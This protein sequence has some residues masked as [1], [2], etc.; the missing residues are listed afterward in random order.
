MAYYS[1]TAYSSRRPAGG[2]RSGGYQGRSGGGSKGRTKQY[3]NPTRFIC[4]AK[5]AEADVYVSE[6]SFDDFLIHP[7]LKQNMMT[8]G[9]VSPSQIQDKAIPHGLLGKDIVGIANTGTGK[10][11]A[12]AVP[13][14]HKL[15]EDRTARALIM[16]PTRELASQIEQECRNLAKASGLTGVVLVGGVPIYPQKRDLRHHPSIVIGTPGRI[17]DHIEQKTLEISKFN[18]VVLDEVDRMLD[19]GFINDIRSILDKLP[20]DRQSLFFSAT[21]D[22]KIES[23]VHSFLS[24]PVVISVK[25]AETSDNVEQGIIRASGKSEKIK[26]LHEVL[27][28]DNVAKVLI[29]DE[30]Q[31]SVESLS[32]ELL[33][34]GFS[35]DALHGGKS[36]P[37]RTRAL[38][39]FKN[40]EVTVLVAT[41]VAARGID[42]SDITH[43]INFTTPM[44]YEDYVHRIG[45]AGRAGR[46]GYAL[47]FVGE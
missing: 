35:A 2:R 30:T 10:T 21:M 33:S 22:P 15:M 32:Q 47:T 14:L 45:R 17:K 16:A 1:S 41:D 3:I 5:M 20:R 6:N 23:L 12:F 25:T 37:Q 13:M 24:D 7:T 40:S 38:K 39:R 19:M 29:F 46:M 11:A 42:I 28:Q 44:S 9:F 36:Q 31:R 26:K 27:L 43:V 34:R 4:S 18:L 8:M